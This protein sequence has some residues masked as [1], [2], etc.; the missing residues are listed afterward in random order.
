MGGKFVNILSSINGEGR[1]M[2]GWP[3]P[4]PRI[5]RKTKEVLAL[6]RRQKVDWLVRNGF[7]KSDRLKEA[8]LKVPR[9][10]FVPYEY[11]DYTYLEVPLPLPGLNATISCPH[12]YPLFYEALQLRGGDRFLEVG[13]GSGYSAALAREV[14]GDEGLVVT[15]EIDED[16][17]RFAKDNLS[18]LGYYDV[19]VIL[20]DGSKGYA[21]LAPYAKIAVT[22]T[23]PSIPQPLIEQL[24]DGGRLIAPVGP[25]D[26]VQKL[27]L[28]SKDG[29]KLKMESVE[30]VLY[31]PLRGEY[32]WI[33]TTF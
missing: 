16:T 6:E 13:S 31:V 8:M 20:G 1:G 32:G 23:C 5:P 33:K 15:I 21:P 7:L 24:A 22:A 3:I 27:M 18:R 2:I 26:D 19:V 17:Y 30:E 4:P 10:E 14:V 25:P 29:G 12:S 11:R 28:L 9:E